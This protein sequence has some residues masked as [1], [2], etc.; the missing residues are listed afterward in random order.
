MT[1]TEA[2]RDIRG[3]ASAGRIVLT[4]HARQR[5]R[6]RSVDREDLRHALADA[7]AC[8]LEEDDKWRVFTSDLDGN[9]LQVIVAIEAGVV[10]V[11][12]F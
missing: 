3:Y 7:A 11:T 4:G 10:V 9:E 2:L 6:D 1:P 5:M 8:E 12:L